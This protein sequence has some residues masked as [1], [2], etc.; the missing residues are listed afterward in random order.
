MALSIVSLVIA[1]I[2][3]AVNLS[4]LMR[5]PRIIAEWS[6]ITEGGDYGPPYEGLSIIATARRRPIEVDELGIVLLTKRTW[7][8]RLP[9]WLHEEKPLRY[10]VGVRGD[11]PRRLQDGDSVRGFAELETTAEEFYGRDGVSYAYV[12][13]SGTIYLAR[14]SKWSRWLQKRR[15]FAEQS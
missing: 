13:G 2:A 8:R 10:A 3:L 5:R 12:M 9:E 7:R 11:L 6:Y 4:G 1:V 15:R 14:D